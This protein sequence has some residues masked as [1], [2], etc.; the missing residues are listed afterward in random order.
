MQ[1]FM[2]ALLECSVSMTAV[3]L[4]YMAVTPFLQNRFTAKGRY[5]AW[6]AIVI[7]LIIPFRFHLPASVV[8]VDALVPALKNASRSSLD[9][10][11]SPATATA[12]AFPWYVLAGG[13]WIAGVIVFLAY[14]AIRHRRLLYIMKRWSAECSDRQALRM[15]QDV[16]ANLNITRQVDLRVCPGIFSPMLVGFVRPVILLPSDHIPANE[17]LF[18]LKHEL[19]HLKRGDLGCK[20][21]VLL[22]TALHWFNPFVYRMA[23]EIA[24]QCELSC[25]EEVVRHSDTNHRQQ[26]VEAI[27]GV[28]KKQ[29]RG[30]SVFS[31]SFSD[32][33]LSMKNRV[34]SIMDTRSKKW[35]ISLLSVIVLAAIGTGAVLKLSPT[36]SETATPEP[37][38]PITASGSVAG[39]EKNEPPASLADP[40]SP[41][42]SPEGKMRGTALEPGIPERG[43]SVPDATPLLV[44]MPASESRISRQ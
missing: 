21:L 24:L 39:Q 6:L 7:G 29:S 30:P 43:V 41:A 13:F 10:A 15:L 11:V 27:I 26:Y 28:M 14:H 42:D 20:T 31:T 38:R 44:P 33:R 5:Y 1:S 8:S 34:L 23:R 2:V 4:L 16:Q 37:T 22:A 36:K 40:A 17:L 9:Q 35:G 19:I 32:S 25:D 12:A 18:I 3:G